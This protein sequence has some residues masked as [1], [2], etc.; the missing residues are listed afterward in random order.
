MLTSAQRQATLA[1]IST[2]R[3]L[4]LC[5]DLEALDRLPGG[6]G[7]DEAGRRM[8][9]RLQQAGAT[10]V[11][12]EAYPTG[13]EHRYFG[14][15]EQRRPFPRKAELWLQ[16]RDDGEILICRRSDN[17]ACCM[18]AQRST[19]LEGELYEVVDVGF[20]TRAS[21]YR[22]RSMSGKLAL[23]SGHHFQ[24]AMLEALG[25]RQ[26]A[27]LLCGPGSQLFDADRVVH[28]QLGDPDLF[29]GHRPLGFNLSGRQY[30]RLVNLL[31]AG[32]SVKMR[33]AVEVTTDS[34]ELPVV[35]AV[36]EG[37]DLSH[38][39]VLLVAD[40]G[41]PLGPACLE[42]LL[43]TMAGLVVEGQVPPP[44]RS[45]EL[46]L[47]PG[48]VGTVA[49]LHTRRQQADQLKA[50]LYLSLETAAAAARVK[51]QR[52]PGRCPAF[53]MD[54]LEDQLRWAATVEGSFRVD[55]PM[56]VGHL[57]YASESPVLPFVDSD[58][59]IPALWLRCEDEPGSLPG[60]ALAAPHGPLHRLVAALSCATLELCGMEGA[61]LPRLLC[62]SHTKAHLRLG[63]RAERLRDRIRLDLQ[64]DDPPSAAARHL[65][66]QTDSS[67]K[68]GLL[69][70][71]AL[72]EGC[73]DFL[74]GAGRH[75]LQ[76][77]EVSGDLQQA[78]AGLIR[79]LQQEVAASLGPR[80]R[81]AMTRRPLSAL[82]RRA[83]S[84][85][86]FRLF[87]G[88]LPVRYLLRE[89]APDQRPWLA[90]NA[91]ALAAQPAADE[92]VQWIDGERT[93]LQMFDLLHLD[94]PQADLKL[95]WRYLEVMQ[96]A[97]LVELRQRQTVQQV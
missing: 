36:L 76:L 23:T 62:G 7:L 35:R 22:G 8:R 44:R 46:L 5:A 91:G 84:V 18:G 33:A 3:V 60:G 68:E 32:E 70:E 21:D 50:A 49:R 34:G 95:L 55:T 54:L 39:R 42:E 15:S 52:P 53:Q 56:T 6:P 13:P 40:L 93:L 78:T 96:S 83:D 29:Q 51:I 92:L 63:R 27:G 37:S 45:L 82:E 41:S 80:A 16:T 72:L 31:A 30:N 94:H 89:A 75:A 69:R 71:Q 12:L 86:V 66:W 14:W 26:A 4:A 25:K 2:S 90:H 73:C 43:R 57:P 64:Q 17:F 48:D 79:S 88:P 85:V 10:R 81:L 28:N 67:M 47:V 97:G 65:L 1:R 61:D 19:E 38:Q 77:A 59:S 24:A 20:G 87:Q 58:V 11:Q 9:E 74:D